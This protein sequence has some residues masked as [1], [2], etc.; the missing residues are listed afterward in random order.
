MIITWRSPRPACCVEMGNSNHQIS[1]PTS[2]S[3]RLQL[4][5]PLKNPLPNTLPIILPRMTL[6]GPILPILPSQPPHT[7]PEHCLHTPRKQIHTHRPVGIAIER[8]PGILSIPF[9][10]EVVVRDDLGWFR[11]RV[12][13]RNAV[14]GEAY[15][16]FNCDMGRIRGRS[17]RGNKSQLL[18]LDIDTVKQ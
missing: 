9:D 4:N 16:T 7:R 14:T 2:Q 17:S 3:R 1:I 5:R 11:T 13:G 15:N 12:A 18:F 8:L 10:P 6:R